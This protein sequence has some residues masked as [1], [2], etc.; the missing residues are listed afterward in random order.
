MVGVTVS[1]DMQRTSSFR[2]KL[3]QVVLGCDGESYTECSS[4]FREGVPERLGLLVDIERMGTTGG[5]GMQKRG[6]LEE[7]DVKGKVRKAAGG[8]GTASAG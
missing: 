4:A 2:Q 3:E 5:L 8:R 6:R 7:T 1:A